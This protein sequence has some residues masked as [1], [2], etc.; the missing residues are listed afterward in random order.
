MGM[1]VFK[2]YNNDEILGWFC[3]G[4]DS[5]YDDPFREVTLP[6]VE[7]SSNRVLDGYKTAQGPI[8]PGN[9]TC[10]MAA[11][12]DARFVSRN[13]FDPPS[14]ASLHVSV[15]V[16]D[17]AFFTPTQAEI[18]EG[19]ESACAG[20]LLIPSDNLF[21]VAAHDPNPPDHTGKTSDVVAL[22]DDGPESGC[23]EV[24]SDYSSNCFARLPLIQED[25]NRSISDGPPSTKFQAVV[26]GSVVSLPPVIHRSNPFYQAG[27]KE[28]GLYHCPYEGQ[29]CKYKPKTN[30]STPISGHIVASSNLAASNSSRPEH[31]FFDMSGKHMECMVMAKNPF[32]ASMKVANA[33][34]RETAFLESGT[35][36]IT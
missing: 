12:F 6:P 17:D 21:H 23:A 11:R 3:N 26:N 7:G 4:N 27:P 24:A 33:Q 1:D 25:S 22:D 5:K 2:Q 14:E 8:A 29:G 10:N 9:G 30:I 13:D 18:K 28:D 34:N 16:Y 32:L 19:S 31:A 20:L 15:P 36:L 35:W